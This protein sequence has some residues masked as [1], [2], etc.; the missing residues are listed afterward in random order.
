MEYI[1]SLRTH[2]L[3]EGISDKEIQ[4]LLG[5]LQSYTKTFRK[6]EYILMEGTPI[7]FIA[8]VLSGRVLMEQEDREGNS[9]IFA[10]I[11]TDHTLGDT[12]I[13]VDIQNSN[14]C[15]KAATNSRLLMIHYENFFSFCA[16]ACNCHKT[17]L[18]NLISCIAS[19]NRQLTDKLEILSQKN[20][21]DKI[22]TYLMILLRQQNSKTI[23]S[24]LNRVEMADYL[25]VNRSAMTRE[26]AVMRREGILDYEHN[27]FTLNM[28]NTEL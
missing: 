25:C 13:S 22:L 19:K 14:V 6:N 17:L 5:C 7:N 11:T 3:F 1:T 21:R 27:T 12:F 15:Y 20:L 23:H 24:P 8:I 4:K 16:N 2:P 9:S 26:L 18:Y 28:S 10:E